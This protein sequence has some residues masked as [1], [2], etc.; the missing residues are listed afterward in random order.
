MYIK[1]I[2]QTALVGSTIITTYG[3]LVNGKPRIV[4]DSKEKL[5]L[6]ISALNGGK[7]AH[8]LS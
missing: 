2:K 1:I 6:F 4:L 7:N 8:S 3:V 5:D